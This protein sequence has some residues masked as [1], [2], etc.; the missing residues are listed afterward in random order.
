MD[1]QTLSNYGWIV[2]CVL[3]IAVMVALATP[4][5][6]FVKTATEN[7]T[8]GMFNVEQKAL[9]A[10][11]LSIADQSFNNDVGIQYTMLEGGGQTVT[12]EGGG[13]FRSEADYSKFTGVL[14]D[15]QSVDPSNYTSQEGST[16]VR[17]K[18]DYIST[19]KL[20]THTLTILSNDGKSDCEFVVDGISTK[21]GGMLTIVNYRNLLETG[22][23]TTSDDIVFNWYVC[24]E[25]GDV[26]LDESNEYGIKLGGTSKNSLTGVTLSNA[27]VTTTL[28]GFY[29]TIYYKL[30]TPSG[31]VYRSSKVVYAPAT[32]PQV[33]NW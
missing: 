6:S 11:G 17:L 4:F 31:E 32:A 23:I 15:G 22:I 12:D 30:T 5:G 19:L 25:T 8:E 2:I 28:S 20:G 3:V 21:Y 9:S 10:G 18:S 29:G 27:Y 13:G 1:K 33:V 26:L 16:I 24:E 7:T 14:V